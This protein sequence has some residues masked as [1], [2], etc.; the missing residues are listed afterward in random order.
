MK[1]TSEA[2]K[3]Q[4]IEQLESLRKKMIQ[5]ANTF[6]IHH[7]MVLSYSRKIDETHNKIMKLQQTEK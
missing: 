7:P 3:I 1:A 5:T 2:K 4:N 6:G